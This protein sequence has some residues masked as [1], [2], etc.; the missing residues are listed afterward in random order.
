[1]DGAALARANELFLNEEYADCL[2]ALTSLCTYG[3]FRAFLLSGPAHG[4]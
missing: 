1:M 3:G 2:A 4:A